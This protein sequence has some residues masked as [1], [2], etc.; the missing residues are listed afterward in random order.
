MQPPLDNQAMKELE[1]HLRASYKLIH[2]CTQEEI[3]AE[4]S[5]LELARGGKAREY[6]AWTATVCEMST[7][8]RRPTARKGDTRPPKRPWIGSSHA[9]VRTVTKAPQASMFSRTCTPL[10]AA[11]APRL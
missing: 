8:R 11:A 9:N 2:F 10:L 6:Y 1:A 4:E 7:A 3:R 5:L